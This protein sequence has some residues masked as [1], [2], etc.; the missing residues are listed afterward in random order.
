M[1][2]ERKSA[3]EAAMVLAITMDRSLIDGVE[4]EMFSGLSRDAF[5]EVKA[6]VDGTSIGTAN[7]DKLL[8]SR[9]GVARRDGEKVNAAVTRTL[10]VNAEA[11]RLHSDYMRQRL[12][13]ASGR[14]SK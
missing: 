2:T 13:L 4:P 8:L 1:D 9:F 5:T 6:A 7:L 3:L 11:K 12:A 10:G 14:E